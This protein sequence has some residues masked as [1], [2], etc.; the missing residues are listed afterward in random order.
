MRRLGLLTA[1]LL[2]TFVVPV[3]PA[4]ASQENA[5]TFAQIM[6]ERTNSVPHPC[7]LGFEG[8]GPATVFVCAKAADEFKEFKAAWDRETAKEGMGVEALAAWASAGSSRMRWYEMGDRWVVVTYE[9]GN[10]EVVISYPR[11]REGVLPL[12]PEIKAP[13]RVPP[14]GSAAEERQKARRTVGTDA[15]GTVVVSAVVRED[16]TVGDPEVLGCIPRHR[17]LEAAA[18]QT[19]S[20][21]RYDPATRDGKPVRI[22]MA[23]TV[24]YGP[25]GSLEIHS[26]A[27]AIS[28]P[29]RITPQA[30]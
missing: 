17:G 10:R 23:A 28:Q 29:D 20:G 16:G 7:V 8:S 19:V 30:P 26:N 14:T 22:A 25:G 5:A 9:L 27:P 13:R 24:N 15:R 1:L 4:A 3:A 21:W 11:D 12:T 2:M 6:I 18:L